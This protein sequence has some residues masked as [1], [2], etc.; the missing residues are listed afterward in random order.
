MKDLAGRAVLVTGAAQGIGRA[1]ALAFADKGCMLSLI[2][3]D[4][5]RL[6][7]VRAEVESKGVKAV[8]MRIDVTQESQVDH[9]VTETIKALGRLDVM[10]NNAGVGL[11]GP[12][13]AT[14]IEDWR[15]IIDINVWS[16]IYAVRAVLPYFKDRGEGHLVQIASAAGILGTLDSDAYCATKFAVYGLAESMAIRFHGTGIGVTVVCPQWVATDIVEHG[17]MASE[18]EIDVESAKANL[19]GVLKAV[20]IPPEKVAAD[21]VS[22]V[23]EDRFLVL[24]HPGIL[25]FAQLKWSDP[26]A[27]I[28]KA[29]RAQKNREHL[30]GKA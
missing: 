28:A 12:A 11:N 21:I 16:H 1:T 2:D 14:S 23:E 9:M 17:R 19:G 5:D 25:K 26:E 30:T 20:G 22:G 27:Y 29:S 3:I 13:E 18:Q 15:W 8:A 6:D 24:P 7:E 10:V 4:A